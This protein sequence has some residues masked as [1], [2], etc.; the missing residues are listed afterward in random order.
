MNFINLKS[1][2]VQLHHCAL[3]PLTPSISYLGHIARPT[4]RYTCTFKTLHPWTTTPPQVATGGGKGAHT[5]FTRLFWCNEWTYK[6]L[7]SRTEIRRG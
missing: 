6:M 5:S 2:S 3:Q 1:N 7:S 4:S